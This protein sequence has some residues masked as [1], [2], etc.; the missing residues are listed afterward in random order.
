MTGHNLASLV[1]VY[2]NTS[3]LAASNTGLNLSNGESIFKAPILIADTNQAPADPQGI[4]FADFDG[5]GRDDLAYLTPAGILQV[6]LNKANLHQH[7][8]T[9][10]D[11]TAL[12]IN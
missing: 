2:P 6:W 4:R 7:S 9:E 11:P 1:Y 12:N 8:S 3:I 5:D 10:P